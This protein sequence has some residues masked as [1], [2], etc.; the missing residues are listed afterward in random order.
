VRTN[1]V[2]GGDFLSPRIKLLHLSSSSR[3][4]RQ[5]DESTI[6]ERG[7]GK[8]ARNNNKDRSEGKKRLFVKKTAAAK[9]VRAR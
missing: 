1:D 9:K 4:E 7:K 5:A 6:C 3:K 2:V 8:E